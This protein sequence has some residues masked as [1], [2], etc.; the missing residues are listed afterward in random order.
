MTDVT[1]D[2]VPHLCGF[3]SPRRS[4]STITHLHDYLSTRNILRARPGVYQHE[5]QNEA[6]GVK[7]TRRHFAKA[8]SVVFLSPM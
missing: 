1:S 7:Q 5:K 4:N 2:T 3:D 8:S 6:N